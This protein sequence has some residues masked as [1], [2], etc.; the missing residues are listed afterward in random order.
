VELNK[1]ADKESLATES[2]FSLACHK[3]FRLLWNLKVDMSP[4]LDS[5]LSQ[6][7]P[8]HTLQLYIFKIQFNII[9]LSKRR[10]SKWSLPF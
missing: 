8:V 9:L 3:K 10:T 2:E 5:I 6:I 4:P 7:N 1:E